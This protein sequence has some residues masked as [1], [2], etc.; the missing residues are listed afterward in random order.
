MWYKD[1]AVKK[2]VAVFITVELNG[3]LLHRRYV[4]GV[5][6]RGIFAVFV[7]HPEKV[8]VQVHRVMHHRQVVKRNAGHFIRL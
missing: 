5:L 4:D 3:D 2:P 6:Q 7:D 1:V 8:P